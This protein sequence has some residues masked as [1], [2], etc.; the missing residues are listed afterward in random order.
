MSIK[1]NAY[2]KIKNAYISVLNEI[3]AETVKCTFDGMTETEIAFIEKQTTMI[4]L[5]LKDLT[6]WGLKRAYTY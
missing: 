4:N 1:Y 6:L 2:K 5:I 3:T